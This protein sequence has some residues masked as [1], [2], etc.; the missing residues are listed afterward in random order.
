[1]ADRTFL[2][3]GDKS[4]KINKSAKNIAALL[5]VFSVGFGCKFFRTDKAVEIPT[6]TRTKITKITLKE[7]LGN[8]GIETV[9]A[10][11]NAKPNPLTLHL[12]F[13]KSN[14]DFN[15]NREEF[16]N[17]G[18]LVNTLNEVFREREATGVLIEGT[19]EV[20]KRITL[21][22]DDDYIADCNAKGIYIEDFEKLVDNLRKESFDQIKLDLNE[23][24]HVQFPT[25]S[26]EKALSSKSVSAPN[27]ESKTISGGVV[28]GK[29]TALVKP[30]Y[31][32][33][34]K[35][36]RASGAVNVQVTINEQGNVISASAVS[37]HPLLRSAAV[38]AAKASKFSPTSLS[39]KPIKVS[40]IIVYNF[41]PE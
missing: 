17:F 20:Y 4:M 21:P 41:T 35:A 30:A 5:I 18:A 23:P 24:N 40:G 15:L 32:A 19:N 36:V 7:R 37:G 6:E 27:A 1:M 12:K 22:A 33:A 39:G 8:K 11:S 29:A 28:N 34:A 31:P 16:E 14:T 25:L 13:S 10:P 2:V 9:S 3:T 38:Q 26:D